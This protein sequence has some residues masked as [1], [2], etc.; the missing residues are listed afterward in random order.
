[1]NLIIVGGGF[2]GA[3]IA[4][5]LGEINDIN[6]SLIDKKTYFEYRPSLPKLISNKDHSK[7]ITAKYNKFLEKIEII[8]EEVISISQKKIQTKKNEYFFDYLVISSGINY[9][10]FLKNKKNVF[11]VS[12][13]EK[14][15][16]TVKKIKK[17]EKILIVGGGLIGVEVAGEI[18]TRFPEKRLV[19]VH[20]KD[21]LIER[22]PKKASKIA[23]DFFKEKNVEI[24]FN[25]KV[26]E[27]KNNI[28]ITNKKRK[29]DANICIWCAGVKCDSSFMKDFDDNVLSK[30]GCLKIDKNLRLKGYNNI[31]VGGDITDITEEKTAQNS[32]R[33]AKVISKNIKNILQN[34]PLKEYK[35]IK[36]PLFISLGSKKGILVFRNFFYSGFIPIFVKN[37][38]ESWFFHMIGL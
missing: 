10:I 26:V 8:H 12:E 20:S 2:C 36:G 1:M 33:H 21:R 17:S 6:I 37:F 23:E 34:K 30:K 11:I 29:I 27:N 31:F 32:E 14:C 18:S 28:F 25:E 16:K 15:K 3:S 7:K 22:N 19:I 13:F 4:Q 38:I 35:K 9:P 24:I 5:K